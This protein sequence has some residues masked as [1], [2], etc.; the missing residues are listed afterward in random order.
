MP[1]PVVDQH[2]VIILADAIRGRCQERQHI[3]RQRHQIVREV[4]LHDRVVDLTEDH[5]GYQV[6]VEND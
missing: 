4:H 2:T 6:V 3:G 5:I 1:N